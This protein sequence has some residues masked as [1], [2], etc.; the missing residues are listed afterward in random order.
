MNKI[1]V[2]TRLTLRRPVAAA[3]L[4]VLGAMALPAWASDPQ[5]QAQVAAL[6]QTVST[7]AGQ[8]ATLQ[9]TVANQGTQ[10]TNLQKSVIPL[11]TVVSFD[12]AHN[13]VQFRGVN[14]QIVNGT[15]STSTIDSKA[16]GN[17]IIGYNEADDGNRGVCSDGTSQFQTECVLAGGVWTRTLSGSHNLVVGSGNGYSSYGG[18]VVGQ[19][20]LTTRKFAVVSGGQRNTAS[21]DLSSVSGGQDNTAGGNFS[22]VSGGFGNTASSSQSSV[23]GGESNTASAVASSVSGGSANTASGIGSSVSGGLSIV[24]FTTNGWAAGGDK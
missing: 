4:G 12:P 9:S 19:D 20:S 14:V 15:G 11:L 24:G 1:S 2:H 3:T 18:M 8:L 10:I 13:L 21:G 16:T 7:Q 17:L 6:Q 22:S 23:S 5:L